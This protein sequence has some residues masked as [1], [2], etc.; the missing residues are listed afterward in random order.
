MEEQELIARIDSTELYRLGPR[1]LTLSTRMLNQYPVR[2][3]AA[4]YLFQLS[5]ELG[6]TAALATYSNGYV[7]YLDCKEGP[8]PISVVLRAGGRAPAHAVPSGRVQLAYLDSAELDRLGE[9]GFEPGKD[10]E[11][12]SIQGLKQ[13]MAEIR[14][15]GYDVGGRWLPGVSAVA[16][17]ILDLN[18]RPIAAIT[19]VAF[20]GQ[21]TDEQV[22]GMVAALKAATEAIGAKMGNLHG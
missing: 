10:G 18:G 2:E 9:K 12:F 4:P 16:A 13:T 8:D 14:E 21:F 19:M 15:Q 11:T 22:P 3:I 20:A 17:A 1:I 5:S 6:F 7:T